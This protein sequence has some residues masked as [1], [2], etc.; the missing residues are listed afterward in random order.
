[1]NKQPEISREDILRV[2]PDQLH[3]VVKKIEKLC[4]AVREDA[5]KRGF[6]FGVIVAAT[7]FLAAHLAGVFLGL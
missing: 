5:Y 1:M 2:I 4:T 6:W 7:L 3:I